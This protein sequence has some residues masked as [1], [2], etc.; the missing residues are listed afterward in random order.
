VDVKVSLM[1]FVSNSYRWGLS[2]RQTYIKEDLGSTVAV[3]L[4][5]SRISGVIEQKV[6]KQVEPPQLKYLSD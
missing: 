4:W 3:D 5:I 2:Y 6:G 1:P